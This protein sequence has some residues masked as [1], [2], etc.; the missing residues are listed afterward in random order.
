LTNILKQTAYREEKEVMIPDVP[1]GA[2]RITDPVPFSNV[3]A[4][5][6]KGGGVAPFS[7]GGLKFTPEFGSELSFLPGQKLKFFYQIWAAP[8]TARDKKFSVD[9]SYGRVSVPGDVKTIHED[10]TG[11]QFDSAGSLVNGKTIPLNDAG[12]GDYRMTMTLIEDGARRKNFNSVNF[13]VV[14]ANELPGPWDIV[15]EGLSE[16]IKTGA[17]DYERGLCYLAA[18]DTEQAINFLRRSLQKN[19]GD[20]LARA[21][22]VSVY[23]THNSFSEIAELY[24]RSG[25]TDKTDDQTLLQVAESLDHMGNTKKAVDV[26]ESA[27]AVR[28]G[29]GPLYLSLASYYRRLGNEQKASDLERKGKSLMATTKPGA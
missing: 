28:N 12:Y 5:D 4:A 23:F 11:E 7:V 29:T 16:D 22:L 21:R 17:I 2:I 26:L 15:D 9:Y 13:H 6:L 18:G 20:E 8:N 10:F 19:P 3:V 25:V 1:A 14:N 24:S 27:L